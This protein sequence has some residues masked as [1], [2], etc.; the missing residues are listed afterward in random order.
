MMSRVVPPIAGL[1]AIGSIFGAISHEQ[2]L[3]LTGV[4]LAVASAIVTFMTSALHKVREAAREEDKKDRAVQLEDIRAIA[5]FQVEL[6]HRITAESKLLDEL[7]ER[8]NRE[9]CP[10]IVNGLARCNGTEQLVSVTTP[11]APPA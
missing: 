6:E 10:Y 1:G 5:R 9:R 2:I 8:L 11:S 7:E 4:G 3:T